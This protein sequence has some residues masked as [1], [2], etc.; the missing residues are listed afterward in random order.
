ML[1]KASLLNAGIFALS[2]LL[3]ACASLLPESYS[4][5]LLGWVMAALLVIASSRTTKPRRDFFLGG[6]V[7]HA[8]AFYWLSSTLVRFGGFPYPI[9]LLLYLLF[10]LI[11]SLQFLF[12]GWLYARLA[13]TPLVHWG[14]A[15]PSAW[16]A[17]EFLIPRLFPWA[18]AHSQIRWTSFASL[19][20]IAGVAPLSAA[21]L[22][23]TVL[24]L[25]LFGTTVLANPVPRRRCVIGGAVIAPLLLWGYYRSEV[26]RAELAQAP[27][28]RVAMIQGNLDSKA[29]RDITLLEVNIQRYQELSREALRDGAQFL[30]WPE[31]VQNMFMPESVLSVSGTQ[32]H[33][34]PELSVPLLYGG[35]SFRKKSEAE[36]ERIVGPNPSYQDMVRNEAKIFDRFNAAYGVSAEGA[37]LGRYYKRILMP[38]GEF[39]P[40]EDQ[41]PSIRDISPYSGN[42]TAGDLL[43]PI[44]FNVVATDGTPLELSVAVLIC[45]EDLIPAMSREGV[46]RGANVLINLTN[47][48]WFGDTAAPHQ[49]QLLALWRAIETRRYLLRATNTGATTIVN[50]LGETVL[51]LPVFA[52]AKGIQEIQTFT[53]I[54]P[55]VRV[56]DLP[57]W[58]L[59]L[60]VLAFAAFRY[61]AKDH[62]ATAK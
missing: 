42:F 61:R 17:T 8:V 14:L 11:S 38:F 56:G 22:W 50:P 25:S 15:L 18:L 13:R 29:K 54:T 45:Y 32:F 49:H 27:S 12:C 31:S 60:L 19:A 46:Q 44:R 43:D 24:L 59:S 5:L 7:F 51:S 16:L 21:L 52:P 62:S 47:D 48:A 4:S 9:A 10:C 28:V 41:F 2:G 33:P 36:V 58:C 55:Y 53:T 39:L 35:L 37:I 40:F 26:I 30:I 23:M 6:F 34:F 1:H 3:F 57:V 20:E